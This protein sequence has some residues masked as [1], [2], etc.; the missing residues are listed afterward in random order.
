[1]L[2]VES[3]MYKDS[4]DKKGLRAAT[5]VRDDKV[6]KLGVSPHQIEFRT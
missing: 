4:D 1:M 6:L 5:E 3:Q 2:T